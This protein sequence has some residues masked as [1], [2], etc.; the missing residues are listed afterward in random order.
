MARK[1]RSTLRSLK[2]KVTKNETNASSISLAFLVQK[3]SDYA[4]ILFNAYVFNGFES[5]LFC[6]TKDLRCHEYEIKVDAADFYKDFEKY[7]HRRPAQ[8]KHTMIAEG[9]SV[10]RFYFLLTEEVYDKVKADVPDYAGVYVV[11]RL[12]DD[13]FKFVCK[14]RGRELH[15]RKMSD[16]HIVSVLKKYHWRGLKECQI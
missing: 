7:Q 15:A 4:S 1:S 5:D 16:A 9:K 13:Q 10:N 14:K 12:V 2:K 6:V 3:M 8:L 11:R